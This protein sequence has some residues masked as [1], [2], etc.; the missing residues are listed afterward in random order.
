MIGL[1]LDGSDLSPANFPLPTLGPKL[2]RLS[3][4][5]HSGKGFCVVRGIDPGLYAVED[6]TLVYLG[7]QAYIADQRGR[8]DKRGNMLGLC[9]SLGQS[10]DKQ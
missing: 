3:H 4:D 6:Q 9:D 5:V 10:S 1:E 8:Q 7:V 2:G